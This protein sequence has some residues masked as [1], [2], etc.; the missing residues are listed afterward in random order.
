MKIK[1]IILALSLVLSVIILSGCSLQIGG[2][3]KEDD[4]GVF[5]STD[6]GQKWTH[7]VSVPVSGGKTATIANV[8]VRRMTFDPSDSN[9]IYLATEKDGVIYTNDGG[10]NWRQ[11]KQFVSLK[12][13]AVAVDPTDKCNLYVLV[14]HKMFKSTDCGRFWRDVY[15]HQTAEVFLT[16]III[17]H[18]HSSTVYMTTSVGE[19]LRSKDSGQSWA[20]VWR[21][22]NGLFMDL[23]MD[24]K[25]SKIVYAA[26]LKHGVYKTIDGGESWTSLGEGLKNYTGSQEYKS[27]IIDPATANSLILI[28]KFGML[29]TRDGGATWEIIE[30]LPA[31]KKTTIYAVAVNPKNSQEIYYATRTTLVKSLD[32]GATWSSQ[33]LPTKRSANRLIIDPSNPAVIYLGAFKISD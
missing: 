2:S 6:S 22:N 17:D 4:G 25:D 19:I 3:P 27:L 1:K 32:G 15:V 21:V 23:I 12:T 9:T 16:D 24:A 30:L 10:A 13:R 26:T 29:R 5:K 31:S 20:T 28:S 33:A 11:F 8:D 18:S 7:P 14:G